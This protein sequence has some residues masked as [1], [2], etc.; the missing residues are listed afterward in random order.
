M[1]PTAK[2]GVQF[3]DWLDVAYEVLAEFQ[4]YACFSPPEDSFG[5]EYH[6]QFA[7]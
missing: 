2:I 1:V 4:K 3:P 5:E 6:K 7:V